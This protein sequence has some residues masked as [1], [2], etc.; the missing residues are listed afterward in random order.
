MRHPDARRNARSERTFLHALCC[1]L[2]LA[3]AAGSASAT[4]DRVTVQ[5]SE[6][7]EKVSG[8][9]YA[10]A[11]MHGTVARADGT[12][13]EYAVP[14]V[15][16]YP[17]DGGNGVGVVDWPNS[18]YYSVTGHQDLDES[19]T[20]QWARV[21][22]DGYLFE[23]GYTYASVQWNK[24]VTELFA[25][26][27][28]GDDANPLLRGSIERGTDA[29][30]ILRDAARF[31][32]DPGAFEGSDGPRPVDTVL[33]FGFSQTSALQMAFLAGGEN[34]VDG[35]HVYD[36]HLLGVGGYACTTPTDEG[37]FYT[38]ITR[39]DDDALDHDGR[40]ADDGSKVMMI[41]AQSDLEDGLFLSALSRYPDEANWRQYELAGVAHLPSVVFPVEAENQNPADFRP[42]FRAA[43]HN[44][45][46]WTTQGTEPPPSVF[47]EGEVVADGEGQGTL[48]TD[49]DAD[50]N[51]LGG[52]RLPHL[53]A[54]VD[55]TI[56]GAPLGTYTGM[57]LEVD[58]DAHPANV[59][60]LIGG[61]FE[62]FDADELRERYADADTYVRRVTLAADHLL[63]SGY[64]LERDRDAYVSAAQR[65][66]SNLLD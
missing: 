19:M 6:P 11:T 32:R 65:Q 41:S 28:P 2:V 21:A 49:L 61:T 63:A 52:L 55:G 57:N 45:T 18:V 47:I 1:S 51:A 59:F 46:L 29:W 12:V 36:G 22:T 25:D 31:L 3:L 56:T 13:G 30:E 64:I 23:G 66:A 15:L 27:P 40:P 54:T 34:E 4:V 50:G 33:S 60:A 10:E 62:P 53:E 35:D 39:C 58:L 9:T 48:V 26:V 37:P 44:L 24:E 14:M 16:I 8:Y 38:L 43:V 5:S 42:V 17:D 20:Y 7:F